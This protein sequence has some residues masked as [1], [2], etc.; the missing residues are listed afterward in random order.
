[1]KAFLLELKTAKRDLELNCTG[2]ASH[3]LTSGIR[4]TQDQGSKL[5]HP[6][7]GIL[8][9]AGTTLSNPKLEGPRRPSLP[10]AEESGENEERDQ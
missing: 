6:N 10:I 4:G 1:M 7:P 5:G 9:S 8:K 2:T 3:A